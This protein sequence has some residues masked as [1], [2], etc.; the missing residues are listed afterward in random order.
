[1]GLTAG[2]MDRRWGPM[3]GRGSPSPT[4]LSQVQRDLAVTA[5]QWL[6][7]MGDLPFLDNPFATNSFNAFLTGRVTADAVVNGPSPAR[8]MQHDGR[9]ET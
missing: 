9:T 1:M 8:Y 4:G 3:Q 7:S 5:M 2:V 6:T